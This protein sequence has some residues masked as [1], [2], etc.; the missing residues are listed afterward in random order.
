M[1]FDMKVDVLKEINV[2][3][4][5]VKEIEN[6]WNNEIVEFKVNGK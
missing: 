1:V 3:W 4:Q 6:Y 2:E 5:L